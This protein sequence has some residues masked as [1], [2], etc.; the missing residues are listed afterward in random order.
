MATEEPE[1]E[2]VWSKVTTEL[3]EAIASLP[4]RYRV[5]LTEFYFMN[6]SCQRLAE[7]LGCR[8]GAIRMSLSRAR[9]RLR[10]TLKGRDVRVSMSALSTDPAVEG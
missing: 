2:V 10:K 5:I 3:D 1:D 9:R 8:H 6:K 7:E 4:E